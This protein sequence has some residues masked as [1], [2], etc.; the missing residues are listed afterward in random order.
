M[1]SPISSCA[2]TRDG[3]TSLQK[4]E[5]RPVSDGSG[6]AGT[7]SCSFE[8][9]SSPISGLSFFISAL[10]SGEMGRRLKKPFISSPVICSQSAQLPPLPQSISLLPALNPEISI[11]AVFPI[12]PAQLLSAG[13]LVSNS[14]ILQISLSQKRRGYRRI[15][16]YFLSELCRNNLAALCRLRQSLIG[17]NLFGVFS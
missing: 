16:A 13:Y 8:S 4:A 5:L 14:S 3:S 11:S 17:Y 7:A 1:P 6:I 15:V 9:T 2:Y 12:S 10:F